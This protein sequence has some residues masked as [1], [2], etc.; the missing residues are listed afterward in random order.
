MQHYLFIFFSTLFD[1][2]F[3]HFSNEEPNSTKLL[4]CK[5]KCYIENDSSSYKR[6]LQ[7]EKC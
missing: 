6:M 7:L 4:E 2:D 3:A 5:H 1:P